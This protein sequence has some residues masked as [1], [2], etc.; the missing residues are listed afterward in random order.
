MNQKLIDEGITAE[1]AAF[2]Q[3]EKVEAVMRVAL[4]KCVEFATDIEQNALNQLKQGGSDP[5]EV[6]RQQGRGLAATVI[7]QRIEKLLK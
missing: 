4:E 7:R 1:K 2:Y 5:L 6:A 3:A